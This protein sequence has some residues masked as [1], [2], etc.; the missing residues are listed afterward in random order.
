MTDN[1]AMR[2]QAVLGM[3]DEIVA[4]Q[5]RSPG[6]STKALAQLLVETMPKRHS[7]AEKL[8][9]MSKAYVEA[10][11]MLHSLLQAPSLTVQQL[12]TPPQEG[13]Q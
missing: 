12:N 7:D 1:Q 13:N 11:L 8:E 9:L 2:R 6:I 10:L 5:Q 4:E 3:V